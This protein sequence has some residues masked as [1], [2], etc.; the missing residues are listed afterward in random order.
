MY[1]FALSIYRVNVHSMT[2]G[3]KYK[4]QNK[5]IYRYILVYMMTLHTKPKVFLQTPNSNIIPVPPSVPF[6]SI[7]ERV[8]LGAGRI[9]ATFYPSFF[10]RASA[11]V[12]LPR[13]P[14]SR[15]PLSPV[16]VVAG[17]VRRYTSPTTPART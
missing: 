3:S 16:R 10:W 7:I 4:I 1:G 9:G 12:L 2:V 8:P 15:P 6:L 5:D 17:R 11:R 13:R 14:P